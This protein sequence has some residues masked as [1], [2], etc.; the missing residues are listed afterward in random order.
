MQRS[1][2]NA[3][4]ASSSHALVW[5]SVALSSYIKHEFP[6]LQKALMYL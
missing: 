5:S 2:G 3:A 1:V 4:G 6:S